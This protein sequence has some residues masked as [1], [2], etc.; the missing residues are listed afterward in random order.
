MFGSTLA[1]AEHHSELAERYLG[2]P[3]LGA[4]EIAGFAQGEEAVFSLTVN[5]KRLLSMLAEERIRMP[6]PI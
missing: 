1:A 6:R 2:D 4:V 5:A 3:V